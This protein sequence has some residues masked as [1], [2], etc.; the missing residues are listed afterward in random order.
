MHDVSGIV[1]A[2]VLRWLVVISLTDLLITF[3]YIS[4][5]V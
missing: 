3:F 5:D 1:S 4:D 2:S